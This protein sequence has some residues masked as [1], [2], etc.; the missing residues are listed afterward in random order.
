MGFEGVSGVLGGGRGLCFFGFGDLK[1]RISMREQRFG[2]NETE[3]VKWNCEILRGKLKTR[4]LTYLSEE[5][6][7][8]L[9]ALDL[10][11]DTRQFTVED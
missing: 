5:K 6:L 3:E 1:A 7:R 8:L 11:L 10:E 4:L 9:I 2:G